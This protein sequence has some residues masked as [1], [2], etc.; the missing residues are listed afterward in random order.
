MYDYIALY[1]GIAGDIAHCVSIICNFIAQWVGKLDYW[2]QTW[3]NSQTAA[4]WKDLSFFFC[5][6]PCMK[7]PVADGAAPVLQTTVLDTPS[8]VLKLWSVAEMIH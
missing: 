5:K 2:E 6:K 4:G 7:Q 1:E 8:P 3:L